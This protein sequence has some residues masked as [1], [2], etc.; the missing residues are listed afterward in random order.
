MKIVFLADAPYPHTWR[1]VDHFVARGDDCHVISFRPAEISGATVHYLRGVDRLGKAG[2]LVQSRRVKQLVHDLQPDLLHALHL[3]SYG[4][5]GALTGFRP[6]IISPIGTDIL[7]APKLTP[8]HGWLTRFSL[9]RAD[10]ITATG[11]QLATETTRYAPREALVTVVPYGV[12]LDRFVPAVKPAFDEVVIGAVS[13]FSPEKGLRYLIDAF[14]TLRQRYGTRVRLRIAGDGPERR[15]IEAQV[16]RLGIAGAVDLLGW[17]DHSVLAAF[18]TSLDLF[19]MP[20]T[21]EGFGVA[22]VEASASGLPVVASDVH[23]IP[24][25]VR[26][27][28]TGRLVPARDAAA[29]ADALDGLIEDPVLRH[30]MGR[31][32]REYVAAHYDWQQNTRQMELL[33]KR[34]LSERSK[35]VTGAGSA[36]PRSRQPTTARRAG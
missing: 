32:G 28:L 26:D 10:A 6:L 24:D 17:V 11:L 2:Y 5:L 16:H 8:I 15:C 29:L 3:T 25:V 14:A 36:S 31:A 33:Y 21:S 9:A 4:F 20:S 7:E 22:A 19:A 27:G 35:E 34:V 18:L 12:D 13:R 1:W 23:G 30:S